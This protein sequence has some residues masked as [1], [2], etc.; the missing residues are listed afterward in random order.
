MP[1]PYIVIANLPAS[2]A[3]LF[4]N[5][6]LENPYKVT[7]LLEDTPQNCFW[8]ARGFKAGTGVEDVEHLGSV[9]LPQ[10]NPAASYAERILK[11][12]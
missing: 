3:V 10:G 2:S 1:T 9:D 12:V 7:I 4:V 6:N 5:E 8:F 11:I